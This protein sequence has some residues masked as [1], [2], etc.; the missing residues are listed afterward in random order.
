M[1][2][3]AVLSTLAGLVALGLLAACAQPTAYAPADGG[4]GYRE[5]RIAPNRYRVIVSGNRITPRETIADYLLYRAAE[6]TRARDGTAFTMVTRDVEKRTSYRSFGGDPF[7]GPGY[8]GPYGRHVDDCGLFHGYG[9]VT[10]HPEERYRA[11]AEILLHPELP[12]D[13]GPDTYDAKALLNRLA[14]RVEPLRPQAK[15]PQ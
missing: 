13:P 1:R 7:C 6:V 3:R 2:P 9:P 10:V 15:G 8:F 12:S 11:T 5:Q 14:E 4:D